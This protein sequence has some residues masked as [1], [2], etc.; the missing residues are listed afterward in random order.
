MLVHGNPANEAW[1]EAIQDELGQPHPPQ[2]GHISRSGVGRRVR[3]TEGHQGGYNDVGVVQFEGHFKLLQQLYVV[4]LELF[5]DIP[6][7]KE[8]TYLPNT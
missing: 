1:P 6:C 3:G 4:L 7:V 2:R 8:L 5:L